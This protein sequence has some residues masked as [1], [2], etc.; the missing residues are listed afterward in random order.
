MTE[1]S[2]LPW[3]RC[4]EDDHHIMDAC[5][6]AICDMA[7]KYSSLAG[8][9]MDVT[10]ELIVTAVNSHKELV[11]FVEELVNATGK[12]PEL[13]GT[14]VVADAYEVLNKLTKQEKSD[15]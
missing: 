6:Y 12:Y 1:H 9:Q 8:A 4:D 11:G 5:G 14:Q 3:K 13:N 2:K 15:G 10:A 7:D